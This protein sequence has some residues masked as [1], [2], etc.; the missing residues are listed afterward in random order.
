MS[1]YDIRLRLTIRRHGLPE[2]K[3][4]WPCTASEDFTIASLLSQVNEVVTLENGDWG[5][6]DYAVEL[7]DGQGASFECLHFQQVGRVFKH[8]DQ[9]L[10]VFPQLRRPK[11]SLTPE[12]RIR[13]LLTED[14][15]RRRISGRHQ[16]SNDGIH[17]VDGIPFGR[18]R[19]PRGRPILSLPPRKRAR[20][21]YDSAEEDGSDLD[22]EQSEQL[23]LEGPQPE[24]LDSKS[25]DEYEDQE[26][27]PGADSEDENNDFRDED[28]TDGDDSAGEED[29]LGE[30]IRFLQENGLIGD[31]ES[32]RDL[33]Q[34]K[35]QSKSPAQHIAARSHSQPRATDFA[36]AAVATLR[37]AFPLTSAATVQSTLEQHQ[38]N[39][40]QSYYELAVENDPVLSFDEVLGRFLTNRFPTSTL[41]PE[42]HNAPAKPFIQEVESEGPGSAIRGTAGSTITL[43]NVNGACKDLVDGTS[44]DTSRGDDSSEPDEEISESDDESLE[45]GDSS[46][47]SEDESSDSIDSSD[48]EDQEQPQRDVAPPSSPSGAARSSENDSWSSSDSGESCGDVDVNGNAAEKQTSQSSDISSDTSSDGS[49]SSDSESSDMSEGSNL[50]SAPEEASARPKTRS[51]PREQQPAQPQQNV[52]TSPPKV[53]ANAPTPTAQK[54]L[55]GRGQGLAKTR[56]RNAR[57]REA[58][59]RQ[60]LAQS[61]SQPEQCDEPSPARKDLLARKQILLS[62]ITE[63]PTEPVQQN[64]DGGEAVSQEPRSNEDD[65]QPTPDTQ[66]AQASKEH[67]IPTSPGSATSPKD[68]TARRRM[69][70]D[71]GAGRRLLF[72]A[73]GLKNPKSK[74]D[75]NKLKEDLM[76]NAQPLRNHRLD[77]PVEAQGDSADVETESGADD[78]RVKTTYRAVECSE[79]SAG[80]SEPPFPF[81]QRWDPRQQYGSRRKRKRRSQNVSQ[82]DH[83]DID[84]SFYGGADDDTRQ[85]KKSK[86]ASHAS[87][88]QG[89]ASNGR[90]GNVELNYDNTPAKCCDTHSQ[91]TDLDDLPSLP[92]NVSVLPPLQVGGIKPGMVITWKQLLLSKATGWQ[93]EM[94]SLTGMTISVND[95]NTIHLI[96]AKRDRERNDKMYDEETGQRIYD[97]F[98][99]PEDSDNEEGGEDDGFRD[100]PWCDLIEPRIVQREPS[101]SVSNSF[102]ADGNIQVGMADPGAP[103]DM[104][105][106]DPTPLGFS[107]SS[108]DGPGPLQAG[109]GIG[110]AVDSMD[111]TSAE[112][113]EAPESAS[114]PSGQNYHHHLIMSAPSVGQA[115]TRES[116]ETSQGQ[117]TENSES[118]VKDSQPG[119]EEHD[120]NGN[121]ARESPSVI[122]TV[123]GPGDESMIDATGRQI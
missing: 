67:G 122:R 9:I 33:G 72:G 90:N 73:L 11:L 12:Y 2:L 10:C 14:L 65:A 28:E 46:L 32:D 60:N 103:D 41:R 116:D 106:G 120:E 98:E 69:R 81:V 34:R 79:D 115:S 7:A 76:K 44:D 117:S 85:S 86:E 25:D 80:P 31:I 96:L 22:S 29:G 23:L 24:N 92:A 91:V 8:D 104:E 121:T 87:Q 55:V 88:K 100:I 56:N 40:R 74:T 118:V 71:M 37:A 51:S 39:I 6:E 16:I 54:P 17:L 47:E 1:S 19:A 57:R 4:V 20:I 15:R 5:L 45:S 59:R 48:N 77:E 102:P 123:E 105:I 50:V 66:A 35:I 114:I 68:E 110:T 95:E 94:L 75:E 112:G 13:S 61:Q 21:V 84:S 43:A 38:S 58:K 93:P 62:A 109:A 99:V 53:V 107:G 70:V 26:F 78:W 36:P 101:S 18:Q 108:P 49:S 97:K 83:C 64:E 82:D 52:H 113:H 42:I 119:G 111:M 3:L 27:V 30:E 63:R 89:T